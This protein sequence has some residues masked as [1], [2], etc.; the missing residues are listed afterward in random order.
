[1]DI[2][3][4]SKKDYNLLYINLKEIV[5]KL[6]NPTTVPATLAPAV[7]EFRETLST[8][9]SVRFASPE[10]AVEG[11]EEG[12][13]GQSAPAR[14]K[15]SAVSSFASEATEGSQEVI[16]L[17]DDNSIDKLLASGP[18]SAVSSISANSAA[19]R[20]PRT[21]SEGSDSGHD[22]S[23]FSDE[24]RREMVRTLSGISGLTLDV[25]PVHRSQSDDRDSSAKSPYRM[26]A[27]EALQIGLILSQQ[28]Q[29]FG[30][31]MYQA[32][33]PEDEPEIEQ[34]N[35]MGYSTEEA[36]LKI[37]QKR[38]QPDLHE[39]DENPAPKVNFAA[40]NG[41]F[42]SYLFMLVCVLPLQMGLES[43]SARFEYDDQFNES[44]DTF[45]G[46]MKSTFGRQSSFFPQVFH[47]DTD[48][49]ASTG[50]KDP[51][52][53]PTASPEDSDDS[54]KVSP[55]A[56]KGESKASTAKPPAAANLAQRQRDM[57]Q[58]ES[59]GSPS[60]KH[61]PILRLSSNDALQIGLLL[62]QQEE[63]HGVNMYD[64]LE[65]SDEATI[66]KL[67][68]QGYSNDEA[69]LEIFNRKFGKTGPQTKWSAV[70]TSQ[71][72]TG[73]LAPPPVPPP[74][75]QQSSF[76]PAPLPSGYLGQRNPP[77]EMSPPPTFASGGSQRQFSADM[78][79]PPAYQSPAQP[80]PPT[81]Y[82]APPVAQQ[83][84]G[85]YPSGGNSQRGAGYSDSVQSGSQRSYQE[86]Q[87]GPYSPPPYQQ[88][89]GQYI[90]S[91]P[92]AYQ[93]DYNHP[94]RPAPIN[95][96]TNS[97]YSPFAALSSLIC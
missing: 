22:P 28:E 81:V 91:P 27:H 25:S 40:M 39:E 17:N 95:V 62:S 18:A 13:Q 14:G 63:E 30:T 35:S 43:S 96:R 58:P 87:P 57:M 29:Q 46:S 61:N 41:V 64:S 42:S 20:R 9:K 48:T 97:L 51:R 6:R 15:L 82:Q 31:N 1:M 26:K 60:K 4:F 52:V 7:S 66:R 65:V 53:P 24:Q 71:P 67:C 74:A 3:C 80:T 11:R 84:P 19:P 70:S 68:Q 36:I 85:A 86:P 78:S 34:L 56:G 44:G 12:K 90:G 72:V 47:G 94:Y 76:S 92:P 69:V 54:V 50:K 5:N 10:D 38:F 32:L 79:P 37:F 33:R 16:E 23:T 75:Q 45:S 83:A 59:E 93:D 49:D 8:K 89:P 21:T 55:K 2:Q 88:G 73:R 77:G